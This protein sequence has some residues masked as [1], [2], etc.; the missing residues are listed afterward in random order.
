M[1]TNSTYTFHSTMKSAPHTHFRVPQ[2]LSPRCCS[3]GQL[4]PLP[5]RSEVW[6][7]LREGQ[8]VKFGCREAVHTQAAPVLCSGLKRQWHECDLSLVSRLVGSLRSSAFLITPAS[9]YI[10]SYAMVKEEPWMM[11]EVEPANENW[12]RCVIESESQL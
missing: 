12:C 3:P 1:T 8:W 4:P 2:A 9:A 6:D 5:H 10:I 11:Q 7:W